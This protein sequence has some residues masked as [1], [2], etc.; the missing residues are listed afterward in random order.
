LIEAPISELE[1]SIAKSQ[2]LMKEASRIVLD[3]FELNSDV[4]KICFPDRY[5]DK[6]GA[7][8]WQKVMNL[9]VSDAPSTCL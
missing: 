4:K 2:Y 3:G 6:R 8:M 1:D 7:V 5:M 9:L